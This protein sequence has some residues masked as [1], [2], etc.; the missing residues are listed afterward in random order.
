MNIIV[1]RSA[2]ADK[3]IHAVS[4]IRVGSPPYSLD[5]P[6]VDIVRGAKAALAGVLITGKRLDPCCLPTP[7][8]SP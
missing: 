1:T 7:H 2:K 8:T 5:D 6:V 4:N 3:V